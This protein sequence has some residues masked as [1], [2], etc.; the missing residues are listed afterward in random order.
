MKRIHHTWVLVADSR[1]ARLLRGHRTRHARAHVEEQ[2]RVE[3]QFAEAEHAR[4][5]PRAGA[6]GHSYASR[7]H[8]S[9]ERLARFARDAWQFVQH[10][11]RELALPQVVL[12][13]PARVLGALRR[14]TPKGLS[15]DLVEH[16]ADL[17]HLSEAELAAHPAITRFLP[18]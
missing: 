15:F 8:E 1:R 4:P 17:A 2:A 9:E 13:A 10:K 3:E 18:S 6:A 11:A 12:C 16:E 5:S 7:S 14:A